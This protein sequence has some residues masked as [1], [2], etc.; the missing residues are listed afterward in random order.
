MPLR[1]EQLVEPQIER[2]AV[3]AEAAVEHQHRAPQDRELA[4]RMMLG[5]FLQRLEAPRHIDQLGLRLAQSPAC[6]PDR[7]DG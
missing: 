1:L 4:E 6:C 5:V 2:A 7:P 3:E